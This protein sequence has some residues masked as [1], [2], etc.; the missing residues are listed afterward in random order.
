VEPALPAVADS[1][2]VGDLEHKGWSV[3]ADWLS[4]DVVAALV[5][6]ARRER[7]AGSFR[8]AGV[9][10]ERHVE[11]AVRGDEIL[12]LDPASA[13][14]AQ[15]VVF[16]RLE[17]LRETLNRELQL[18]AVE[19]ELHFAVYPAGGAYPR[20]LDRFRDADSRVLS[21]VLYLNE[22]WSDADGGELRLHVGAEPRFVDV[23]PRGGTLVAFLSD[24]FP[25]EV[26]P[27]RRER[28]SLAGW[29]RRRAIGR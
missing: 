4:P 16:G 10:R 11:A 7:T 29:F 2:L 8:S 27:A 1:G 28:L 23:V 13:S 12:W 22:A 24:R 5:A 26:L 14:A 19:L 6:E 25:H 3:G 18:G 15:R 9:G 21:V 20:H 17:S